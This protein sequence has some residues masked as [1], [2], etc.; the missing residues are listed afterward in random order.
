MKPPIVLRI[1]VTLCL[2]SSAAGAQRLPLPQQVPPSLTWPQF[3]QVFDGYMANDSVVGGAAML[4]RNGRVVAHHER[5]MADRALGQRVDTN[6]IFHWASI[7]K[8]FGAIAIMQL[9]DHG[10]LSLDDPVTKYIPELRRVHDPYGS[11]DSVTIRMLLSHSAGF[12]TMTWRY[13]R[14][15]PWEPFEPTTWNQLV[16]M[17]PYQELSFKPGERFQY[18]NPGYIYLGRIVELVTGSPW[19]AYVQKNIL[20]PLGMTRSY[21]RETPYYLAQDRSNNYYVKRDSTGTARVVANGRDF[22][23]GI[24]VS[25]GGLNAPLSDMARYLAFL[26]NATGGDAAVQRRYDAVLKHSTLVEMWHPLYSASNMLYATG[27]T[28]VYPESIGLSFFMMP[29]NGVDF[30]THSGSQAGFRA[31][32]AINPNTGAGGIFAV[33]TGSLLPPVASHPTIR[34]AM[35]AV[36]SLLH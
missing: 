8:T 12:Q 35:E 16:A 13:K 11:I 22:D 33:N 3:V 1:L 30:V 27:D 20:A 10:K 29:R 26:S 25:N 9:R 7:T 32:I 2:V 6:T 15:L 5:G 31:F 24:T 36:L 18:S 4:L 21:F 28:P 14:G 19:E 17:M 23:P 34:T